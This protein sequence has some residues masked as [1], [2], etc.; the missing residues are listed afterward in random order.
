MYLVHF[1]W[2]YCRYLTC[3]PNGRA[4]LYLPYTGIVFYKS[5]IKPD[6]YS[7]ISLDCE[8]I[9]FRTYPLVGSSFYDTFL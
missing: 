6:S 3:P 8:A 9:V 5:I 1:I 2:I 4:A 7:E